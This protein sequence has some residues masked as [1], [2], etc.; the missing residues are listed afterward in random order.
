MVSFCDWEGSWLMSQG[1]RYRPGGSVMGTGGARNPT[2][3]LQALA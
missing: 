2:L 1:L 3:T